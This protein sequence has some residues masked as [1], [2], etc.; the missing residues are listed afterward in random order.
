[1][2]EDGVDVA[3]NVAEAEDSISEGWVLLDSWDKV[4]AQV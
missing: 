2:E 4:V 3:W 1:M